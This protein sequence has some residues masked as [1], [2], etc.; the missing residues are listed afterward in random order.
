MYVRFMLCLLFVVLQ[1][2]DSYAPENH[3]KSRDKL[4]WIFRFLKAGLRGIFCFIKA[5]RCH[6]RSWVVTQR[7]Q[8]YITIQI[9]C[10]SH[11]NGSVKL[12]KRSCQIEIVI[13]RSKSKT[14]I[15]ASITSDSAI[16]NALWVTEDCGYWES[17]I[18]FYKVI[19]CSFFYYGD[20]GINKH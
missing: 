16:Q 13:Q 20:Y 1:R 6:I 18:F 19:F 17:E 8:K 3:T 5:G 12:W 7:F 9:H 14:E 15:R 2:A 10:I 11:T 4:R